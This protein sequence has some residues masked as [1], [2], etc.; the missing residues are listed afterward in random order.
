MPS[1]NLSSLHCIYAGHSSITSG[2]DG[3]HT[4]PATADSVPTKA[5]G[6]TLAVCDIGFSPIG[7]VVVR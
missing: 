1:A 5:E 2:A 4:M 6:G 7:F 3:K